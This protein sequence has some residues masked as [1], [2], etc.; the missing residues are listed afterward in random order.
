MP[1]R[2]PSLGGGARYDTGFD[3]GRDHPTLPTGGSS[4]QQPPLSRAELA[5]ARARAFE[6]AMLRARPA[7]G[8]A[9][10]AYAE[11]EK[12]ANEILAYILNG[13]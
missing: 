8:I 9:W 7:P 11:I 1:D 6:L 10:P 4:V 12:V 2:H 5:D 3:N 13:K